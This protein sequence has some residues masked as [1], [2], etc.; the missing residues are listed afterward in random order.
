MNRKTAIRTISLPA[1]AKVNLC[2]AVIGARPDGFHELVTLMAKIDLCDLVTLARTETKGEITC[3]CEGAEG[4][5]ALSGE[6]NLAWQAVD[7]WRQATGDETGVQITIKKRIPA[8]AGLGGG[9]SDAVATLKALNLWNLAPLSFEELKEI[10]SR[11][12][13]DC[14]G[15]LVEGACVAT[16][17]GEKV[18]PLTNQANDRLNAKRLFLFKPPLGF[19]TASVYA[20]LSERQDAY[21]SKES[22]AQ[23]IR[24]WEND[25]IGIHECMANDLE[26]VIIDKYCFVRPLFDILSDRFAMHPMLS[27]SGSCCFAFVPDGCPVS[28]VIDCVKEAWGDE[29]FVAEQRIRS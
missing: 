21:S 24:A 17:R 25:E 5:D 28:Q 26:R 9:S 16:G 22:V 29:A 27:G 3:V 6:K 1:P 19:S 20:G 13:S 4:A 7:L 12:G 8:M 10:S 18:R 23:R 14:S 11:L 2:L 15:F